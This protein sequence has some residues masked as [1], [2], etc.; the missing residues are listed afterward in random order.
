MEV[1]L[2]GRPTLVIRKN[3]PGPHDH[4][5]PTAQGILGLGNMRSGDLQWR[6][7]SSSNYSAPLLPEMARGGGR[8]FAEESQ[9]GLLHR[10]EDLS[11]SLHNFIKLGMVMSTYHPNTGEVE[12]GRSLVVNGQL[13]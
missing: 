9:Q 12:T 13:A 5:S 8:D 2:R 7:F 4:I 3:Y 11:S 10:R 6:D 1:R